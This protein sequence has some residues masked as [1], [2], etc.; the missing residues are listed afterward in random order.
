M[1]ISSLNEKNWWRRKLKK[2]IFLVRLADRQVNVN[3]GFAEPRFIVTV[4]TYNE[5]EWVSKHKIYWFRDWN[6]DNTYFYLW[7]TQWGLTSLFSKKIFFL[8]KKWVRVLRI[9][10]SFRCERQVSSNNINICIGRAQIILIY[11]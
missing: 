4:N 3:V 11:V 5:N 8:S 10:R 6:I 7:I 9:M 1:L 2:I